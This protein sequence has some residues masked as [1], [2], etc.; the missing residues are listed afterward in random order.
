MPLTYQYGFGVQT[1]GQGGF[2]GFAE[3]YAELPFVADDAPLIA[4][5][6]A[7]NLAGC[8]LDVRAG[9]YEGGNGAD[10]DPLNPLRMTSANGVIKLV[11]QAPP[12][13][14]AARG[15]GIGGYGEGG[16]GG[17]F[18]AP[19]QLS[20]FILAAAR[21]ESAGLRT[22]PARVRLFAES[23]FGEGGYGLGGY[24]GS[25]VDKLTAQT[26]NASE[27]I[28]FQPV[29]AVRVTLTLFGLPL[30]VVLPE[31]FLGHA[32]KMP[33]LEMGFDPYHEV[34]TGQAFVSESGREY[35]QLRY[36]KMELSPRWSYLEKSRWTALDTFREAALELKAPFYFSWMPNSRPLETYF[37]R[38]TAKSAPM[39]YVNAQ[40]RSLAL[41][42]VE[43]L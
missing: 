8:Q 4:Y 31:I 5:Q 18:P 39:P 29:N 34:S 33:F 11:Y 17:Y 12:S 24:G 25:V 7:F 37:V 19:L 14:F 41:Q 30:N 15:Y 32:I 28:Q 21:H 36:R 40:Y 43:V 2:G 1:F 20:C 23:G 38:N 6:N 16:F 9:R 42:L 26:A 10:N 22:P 3:K 13:L 27:L 35:P